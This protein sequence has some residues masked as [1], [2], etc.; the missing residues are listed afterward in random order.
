MNAD[1]KFWYKAAKNKGKSFQCTQQE[2]LRIARAY[3]SDPSGKEAGK[4]IN[5][6]GKVVMSDPRAPDPILPCEWEYIEQL[7]ANGFDGSSRGYVMRPKRLFEDLPKIGG[8]HLTYHETYLLYH[9]APVLKDR[10]FSTGMLTELYGSNNI[11]WSRRESLRK[12]GLLE[13]V[14]WTKHCSEYKIKLAVLEYI[15]EY[16]Q[17]MLDRYNQLI[18]EKNNG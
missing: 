6:L 2:R 8:R 17:E 13:H 10:K 5:E 11:G 7:R 14:G 12:I 4:V 18:K 3:E 15:F 1:A 16:G 9:F